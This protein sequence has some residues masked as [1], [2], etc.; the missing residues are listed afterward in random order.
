M[1]DKVTI[2][3]ID[4]TD[5]LAMVIIR[6]GKTEGGVEIES[7]AAGMDKPAAAHVLRHVANLWDGGKA[8]P[9][10]TLTAVNTLAERWERMGK[11]APELG[12]ELLI[13]EPTAAERHQ[14]ERAAT[15]RRAAA[16]LREVLVTGRIPHDLMTDAELDG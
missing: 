2:T 8:D 16:D 14:H 7:A 12:D 4:G 11:S 1:T 9:S 5:A 3:A 10:A 6:P 13:D 15:Y